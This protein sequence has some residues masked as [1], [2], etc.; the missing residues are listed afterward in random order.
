[1]RDLLI[2]RI[3]AVAQ[4]GLY[5]GIMLDGFNHNG[6]GFV[7]RKHHPVTDEEII[8]VML[9]ILRSIRSQVRDDFLILA[10]A[11]RSKLTAYTKHINGTFMETLQDKFFSMPTF[12]TEPYGYTGLKQIE[13]TLLW[14]EQNLRSPQINCLEGWGIGGEAPD[15]PNNLRWMRV[16][17]TMSLTHSDGY[18]IYNTG[19]WEYGGPGHAHIWF[20]FWEADLGSPVGE[21]AQTYQNINGLF[22]REFTNGWAVYNRSGK[23]QAITLPRVSTGVSS[24]KQDITH[25]LPDLDGEIYLRVGKPFDLNRDG[26]INVLDLILISQHFGTA[27]GD[28]N[29]DSTTDI[30]DLT[31][32]AKHLR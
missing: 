4:C 27:E 3:L 14:S 12:G 6:T 21:T 22:I 30:L 8:Q 9:N 29:R 24:T 15:S 25:L 1:M 28:I 17:T 26:T 31:L 2:K 5:D 11:N 32:I 10:N 23:E 7:D 16:F 19:A 18:V 13:D 20:D